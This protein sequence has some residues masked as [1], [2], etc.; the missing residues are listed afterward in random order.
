MNTP[1]IEIRHLSKKYLYPA[2]KRLSYL[3]GPPGNGRAVTEKELW[4]IKNLTFRVNPGEVVGIIGDNGAGKSTLLKILSRITLPTS[5]T[6]I[7]RGK[8]GSLLEVGTGFHPELTGR[9]NIFLNGVILGMTRREIRKRFGE[10]VSFAEIEQFL[11]MPV[12]HYSS[13]MYM[14]L[15]FAVAAYLESEVMIVDE[16]LS[17]G[18]VQFQKKCLGKID[19]VAREKGRTVLFVSHN[20]AAVR[21]LCSRVLLFKHGRLVADGTPQAVI[22]KYLGSRMPNTYGRVWRGEENAPQNESVVL[23]KMMLCDGAGKPIKEISTDTAFDIVIIFRVKKNLAT[24][25]LTLV[26]YDIENNCIF[27]TI[28]NH[29]PNWYGKSMTRGTYKSVCRVPANFF[30][31]LRVKIGINIFGKGFSDLQT[32]SDILEVEIIDGARV[33]GDYYGSYGGVVRPLFEWSTKLL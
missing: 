19:E 13:G 27:G 32:F 6:A 3:H 2:Q 18:D 9:E 11:D 22:G 5:G 16:V 20:L 24:V 29:E 28:N 4:A 8:V 23:K 25:G 15:G 12:K 1:I 30:N 7:L 10:I 21:S 14:R 31:N 33:R 17:V 26:F